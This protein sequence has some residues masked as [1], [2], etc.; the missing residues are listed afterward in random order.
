MVMS[1]IYLL[2]GKTPNEAVTEKNQIYQAS[3][4]T[5]FMSQFGI[6][7]RYH[8]FM[9]QKDT[10]DDGSDKRIMLDKQCVTGFYPAMAYPWHAVL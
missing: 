2:E 1:N 8:S 3:L 10:S 6:M 7:M 5:T 9:S 4:I